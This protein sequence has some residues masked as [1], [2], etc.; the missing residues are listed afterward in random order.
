M[1]SNEAALA[2]SRF[3]FGGVPAEPRATRD[4]LAEQIAAFDPAANLGD[5][6]GTTETLEY[7]RAYRQLPK[8]QSDER[9]ESRR[10]LR[11]LVAQAAADRIDL[12]V[13]TRTPFA[14]R[15][16]HFWSN[17]FA[18]S[19]EKFAA[20]PLAGAFEAEAIRPHVTGRFADMLHAAESH[21]AML[22]YLDQAQ[23]VGPNSALGQ[24]RA[25][26]ARRKVGINENLAREIL[27]LHTLGVRSGY[28]QAD[29]REFAFALTGWT[30]G[31]IRRNIRANTVGFAFH[32]Q[33]HEPATRTVLGKRYAEAGEAQARAIL[34][35]LAQHPATAKHIATKLARHFASDDPPPALVRRL[36]ESFIATQGD[37]SALYT[38]LAQSPEVWSE[39]RTKFLTPIE[40]T[41]A[42]L[43]VTGSNRLPD[44]RLIAMVRNLGQELWKP[45]SP[46]GFEDRA[47]RWAAP[48]ALYRRVEA[49]HGLSRLGSGLDARALAPQ[50]YGEL[51]SPNTS[52]AIRRAESP[53]EA[54]ALLLASPEAMWR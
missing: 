45:G 26:R 25:R 20:A 12:A 16:V 29:V 10:V 35:D 3:G 27:E 19:T 24:R 31:G 34:D 40:W 32:P 21:P 23:S 37:L 22:L 53:A 52:T 47:D 43:R 49:A 7:M 11:L 28:T 4:Y 42:S 51:L 9:T 6:P 38:T 41:I 18:I 36:E 54:M 1:I 50:I 39:E 5:T 8:G 44:R 17:H 2:N 15:M 33:A 48:D 14:E 30:V 13:Q 46:A